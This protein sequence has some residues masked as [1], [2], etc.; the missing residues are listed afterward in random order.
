MNTY[1]F[2]TSTLIG[3]IGILI[4]VWMVFAIGN[5]DY[6]SMNNLYAMLEGFA[7]VGLIAAGLAATMIVG[8]LD[9]SVG[10]VAAVAGIIA[11]KTS[12]LGL[13][14][15]VALTVALAIVYGIVQGYIVGK[16]G[17]NS[18]VFTIATLIGMRGVAYA[19]A[20]TPV[21]MPLARLTMSDALM[22]RLWI[23]SPFSIITLIVLTAI[24]LVFAYTTWGRELYAFGGGRNEARAAGLSTMRP[25]I[26]AFGIS[27]GCAGLA[28]AM[29]SLKSGAAAPFS[30]EALLLTGVTAALVG[31][32][33]LYG[34]RGTM[35]GVGIGILTVQFLV[36]GF[37]SIG[38][39]TY[40]G[41]LATG[42]LLLVVLLVE[43]LTDSPQVKEWRTRRAF[44]KRL[45][46]APA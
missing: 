22:Q 31:G 27:G 35:F 23:F 29:A 6:A 43:F 34:G 41:S 11:V 37:S 28:G 40:V 12:H 15:C 30:F 44:A 16:T 19:L 18:L 4:F 2:F 25:L 33:S 38:A 7:L 20:P 9:L 24:G 46:A 26:L 8:E 14:G 13:V 17:I 39:P 42:T 45:A 1:R 10:S 3:R 21:Q 36:S 32:I 5:P